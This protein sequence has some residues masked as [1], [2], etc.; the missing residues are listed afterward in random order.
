MKTHGVLIYIYILELIYKREH[1][2]S[3]IHVMLG[4]GLDLKGQDCIGWESGI[5][6]LV[7]VRI[8]ARALLFI[9]Y[10]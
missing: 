1:Q 5:A 9:F 7:H 10:Y 2:S 3:N 6:R 8:E 4:Y